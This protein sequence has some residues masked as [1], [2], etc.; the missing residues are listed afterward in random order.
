MCSTVLLT[1]G[2][3]LLAAFPAR[4]QQ[5]SGAAA[6]ESYSSEEVIFQNGDLSLAGT[7]TL[8]KGAVTRYPAALLISG[9]DHMTAMAIRAF[10]NYTS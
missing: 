4:A 9:P 6:A 1:A 5:T 10:S 7:L 8:P 3:L 2:L